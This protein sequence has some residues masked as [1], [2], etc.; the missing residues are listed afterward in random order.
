MNPGPAIFGCY[1]PLPMV[2]RKM[3]AWMQQVVPK[4]G[5]FGAHFYCYT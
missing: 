2:T 1:K 3:C 4:T 5:C